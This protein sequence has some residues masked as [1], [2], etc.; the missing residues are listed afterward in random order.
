MALFSAHLDRLKGEGKQPGPEL[1]ARMDDVRAEYERQLDARF[2]GA[3]GFVDEL[4]LPEEVRPAL[5]LLL[6]AALRNPGPHLGPFQ[7]ASPGAGAPD[8]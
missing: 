8:L 1:E 7:V 6:A 3:R 2:A 4:V 5:A